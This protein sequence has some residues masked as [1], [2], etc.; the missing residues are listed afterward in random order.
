M[1]RPSNPSLPFSSQKKPR[2]APSAADVQYISRY[3]AA[4]F[5]CVNVQTIDKLIRDKAVRA[6]RMG[7]RVI[8][9]RDDLLR[10]VERN[11]VQPT[12]GELTC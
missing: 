3:D 6:S 8:V 7:R 10:Y 1:P 4:A 9:R 11:A 12:K 5:L 2:A